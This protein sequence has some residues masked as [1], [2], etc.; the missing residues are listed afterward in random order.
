MY[1]PGVH[2]LASKNIQKGR[3]YGNSAESQ[4]LK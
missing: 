4:K 2:K 3:R 1:V